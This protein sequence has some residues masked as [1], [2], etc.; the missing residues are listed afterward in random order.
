MQ[1]TKVW[2]DPIGRPARLKAL[3]LTETV[4]LLAVEKGQGAYANCTLNHPALYRGIAAWGETI[5]SLR[6]SLIPLSWQRYDEGNQPF[7]LNEA[8]TL[9][10]TVATGD[11]NTGREGKTPCTKS[12]KGPKTELAITNNALADTLFGDIRTANRR[13]IDARQTWILLFHR[14]EETSEIRCELS[15]PSKMNDEGQVDEWSERIILGPTPFGGA[16]VR[17]S[18]EPPQTP[19]IDIDIKRRA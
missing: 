17:I 4:L 15:C 7:A 5:C 18:N 6:E 13:K 2:S 1:N 8:G 16:A 12:S 14:D 3:G 10:I 9:A 11:E 19:N